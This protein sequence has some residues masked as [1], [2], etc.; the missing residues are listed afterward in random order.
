MNGKKTKQV[1]IPL[2]RAARSL[3]DANLDFGYNSCNIWSR[4]RGKIILGK[5]WLLIVIQLCYNVL[6]PFSNSKWSKVVK[7]VMLTLVQVQVQVT[8][9]SAHCNPLQGNYRIELLH[10]EIRYGI[11]SKV[12]VTIFSNFFSASKASSSTGK[13]N[14]NLLDFLP[15]IFSLG[16]CVSL[17][18]T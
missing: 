18:S 6:W 8:I 12:Q 9:F 5:S 16:Q 2:P 17:A 7:V 13:R 4:C 14:W 11:N 1:L 15:F 10:R 3:F